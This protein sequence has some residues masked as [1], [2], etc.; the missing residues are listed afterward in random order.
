[1]KW[2]GTVSLALAAVATLFSVAAP[3]AAKA[4]GKKPNIVFIL[5]DNVGWG[6]FSV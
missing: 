6:D 5:V 4:Q 1:M 3:P 2:N